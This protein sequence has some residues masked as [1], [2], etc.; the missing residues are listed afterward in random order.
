LNKLVVRRHHRHWWLRQRL[1]APDVARAQLALPGVRW[2][3]YHDR[4]DQLLAYANVW[5]HPRESYVGAWGSRDVAQDGR[6]DLWFHF[7]ATM[8]RWCIEEG[9]P[10][11]VSGQ[12][13][14]AEKVRLGHELRRQWAVLV[15]HRSARS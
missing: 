15:P 8:A 7:N 2:L 5:E 10:G 13:S 14:I 4:A 12:G 1:M 11:Y 3:T 9:R 6:K